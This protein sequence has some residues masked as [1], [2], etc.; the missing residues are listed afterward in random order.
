MKFFKTLTRD[1]K[2]RKSCD[3]FAL[4]NLISV[5][6]FNPIKVSFC[7]T[8]TTIITLPRLYYLILCV[9]K[10]S[11]RQIEEMTNSATQQETNNHTTLPEASPSLLVADQCPFH[12]Y[13]THFWLYS[14]G[15]VKQG[16]LFQIINVI[17]LGNSCANPCIYI[18]IACVIKNWNEINFY[19]KQL[20]WGI[21][22]AL[23]WYV[24][25]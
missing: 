17:F 10:K 11:R 23:L 9:F 6:K 13:W 7:I 12:M 4:R 24:I 19:Q 16:Y 21:R 14:L 22:L 3:F 20:S 18:I 1:I 8:V 5:A 25:M 15:I 2:S